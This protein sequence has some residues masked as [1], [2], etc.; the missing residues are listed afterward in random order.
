MPLSGS[1]V[2][3]IVIACI[4]GAA[5]IAC[6][7]IGIYMYRKNA[8]NGGIIVPPVTRKHHG[9]G[10]G[11]GGG[12]NTNPP[13]VN[14]LAAAM[15]QAAW[16]SQI[17]DAV[18]FLGDEALQNPQ[19]DS[20]TPYMS[21]ADADATIGT[22]II[23]CSTGDR[24]QYLTYFQAVYPTAQSF[25]TLTT[26]QL[27]ALYRSLW[28]IYEV[29]DEAQPDDGWMGPYWKDR[30]I[31][32]SNLYHSKTNGCTTQTNRANQAMLFTG[33][34]MQKSNVWGQR[35]FTESMQGSL[36]RGMRNSPQ[37]LAESPPWGTSA[38]A[39]Y[40]TGGFPSFSYVE[41][42]QFPQEHPNASSTTYTQYG[43]G[44][45]TGCNAQALMSVQYPNTTIWAPK[46]YTGNS[47]DITK[48]LF[49]PGPPSIMPQKYKGGSP[50]WFYFCQGFGEFW[51]MGTTMYCYNYV[52]IFLNAPM[53][54]NSGTQ[55]LGWTSSTQNAF[56][57]KD[58]SSGVLGRNSYGQPKEHDYAD[59]VYSMKLLLEYLSRIAVPGS[60]DNT[61]VQPST[62]TSPVIDT[63][64]NLPGIGYCTSPCT[65]SA[66]GTPPPCN[67]NLN[68]SINT[69]TSLDKQVACLMGVDSYWDDY[70]P[71][72]WIL[73]VVPSNQNPVYPPRSLG[74]T[75][76]VDNRYLVTGWVNGNFYGY[77]TENCACTSSDSCAQTGTL[78]PAGSL[79]KC[80]PNC[81]AFRGGIPGYDPTTGEII[82]GKHFTEDDPLNY[83]DFNGNLVY[84]TWYGK[85]LAM[86]EETALA[87]TAE[88]YSCGDTG[89]E[90]SAMNWPFGCYFGYGQDLG[91]P[92]KAVVAQS[93]FANPGSYML[94]FRFPGEVRANARPGYNVY[95]CQFTM[96]PTSYSSETMPAY[97]FEILTCPIAWGNQGDSLCA[98][99]VSIDITAD[100]DTLRRMACSSKGAVGGYVLPT[101]PAGQGAV[102]FVGSNMGVSNFTTIGPTQTFSIGQPNQINSAITNSLQSSCPGST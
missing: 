50:Q 16:G 42:V 68:A 1:I 91:S 73:S 25:E 67:P 35:I 22:A 77:P 62:W 30:T 58:P 85:P 51:S 79:P 11:G 63:R 76:A 71:D 34:G 46:G 98:A 54:K 3:L 87:L 13:A 89:W 57:F 5:A 100:D 15:Q 49:Q 8:N 43:Y 81:N 33:T 72:L 102:P 7:V 21:L 19:Y 90:C 24:Q 94:L 27:Q 101:S 20:T 64:T 59:P 9:G 78:W 10:G 84:S 23:P 44:H 53:G 26:E 80:S 92:G 83:Y 31:T 61:S 37:V 48:P 40:G 93:S 39:M 2:A 66:P 74:W 69:S 75:K 97:D 65:T 60:C 86:D 99:A 55:M 17:L 18:P 6:L 28:W 4:V 95:S 41:L 96:T 14:P 45:P 56:N 12:G 47:K 38:V 70:A 36:R 32:A 29:N 52:D 88:M 82:Y